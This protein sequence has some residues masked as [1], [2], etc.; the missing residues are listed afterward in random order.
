[1]AK[2]AS[3]KQRYNLIDTRENGYGI[4]VD[5]AFAEYNA[6]EVFISLVKRLFPNINLRYEIVSRRIG[7]RPREEQLLKMWFNN[8]PT[9][10]F[11]VY[12]CQTEG[13]GR[14][15]VSHRPDEARIQWQAY[16][17]WRPPLNTSAV[18]LA[19]IAELKKRDGDLTNK[20]CYIFGIYKRDGDDEDIVV[21][22]LYP[23]ILDR[24]EIA[25]TTNRSLQYEYPDIREAFKSGISCTNKDNGERAVHFRPEHLLWYMFN[26]DRLHTAALADF[27]A[28]AKLRLAEPLADAPAQPTESQDGKK[29]LARNK[30]IYGA[31]GTGKSYALRQQATAAGFKEKRIIRVTFHPNYTYQQF[32]GVYKPTP[33]Y[34]LTNEQ[35]Y[36]SDGSTP[37]ESKEPLIDYTLVAGPLLMLLVAARKEPDE[38]FLLIIE[39]INRAPVAAVFGDVFQLLDRDKDGKSEYEIEFNADI[40][41]YLNRA[42]E[43]KGSKIGLPANLYIWAT[44][45]S[46]D[47]GVMPMDAAFKRRWAFEYLPLDQMESKV[48]DW[49]INFQ[50]VDYKWNA[51]RKELN[52]ALKK[53]NVAEDKLIGPFFLNEAELSDPDTIKNKLLLYLRDDILRHSPESLF[54]KRAF[55]DIVSDY[56][57]G[58]NIFRAGIM[59][60]L[61]KGEPAA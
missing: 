45:N 26:R 16:N 6:G 30:I 21:T 61:Q 44:M 47:Q 34:K 24:S 53:Q 20:E 31:P 17:N 12:C 19:F 46:A 28:E 22:A 23:T 10:H 49:V 3:G 4:L 48:E 43:V 60:M 9:S 1:M 56:V 52:D 37:R 55:S 13:G 2:Q 36:G 8:A 54:A 40:T 50:E 29:I 35:L 14:S 15:R 57:A 42:L 18:A 27:Q 39:E 59:P 38:K 5:E 41:T 32:V 11:F 25:A 33:I 51:F 7:N 58:V